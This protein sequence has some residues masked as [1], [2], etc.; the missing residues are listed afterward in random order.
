MWLLNNDINFI[1]TSLIEN[2]LF[3]FLSPVV[4]FPSEDIHRFIGTFLASKRHLKL[5]Y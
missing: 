5:L 2:F 3:I 1:N 4:W